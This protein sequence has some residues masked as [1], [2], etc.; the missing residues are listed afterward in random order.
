MNIE[1]RLGQSDSSGSYLIDKL[2]ARLHHVEKEDRLIASIMQMAQNL[3]CATAASLL[4]LDEGSHKLYF[5]YASG[6]V[7]NKLTQLHISK[8][9]GIAGWIVQHGKPLI[10]NNPE[11]NKSFYRQIDTATGFRTRSIIGVPIEIDRAVV[12]VIE[13]LNKRNDAD[14]TRDDL[15][16]LLD[17]ARTTARTVELTRMNLD[18]VTSFKGTVC[19]VMSLADAREISGSGHSKQVSEYAVGA[20]RE[21]GLAAED[22]LNIEYASIFHDIGK[23]ALPDR[24]LNKVEDLTDEEWIRMRRHPVTGYILLRDIPFLREAARLVLYHHERYDGLGYPEGLRGEAIPLGAR[25][26]AV[27]DAYAY[28]TTGHAYQEALTHGQAIAELSI[29]EDSQFCPVAV[30]ALK[31]YLD[32]VLP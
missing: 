11:K 16:A 4:L 8:Q 21:L 18:L 27:A 15:K 24:L 14:F 22:L 17:V 25:L 5:R 19:A 12:G 10:V 3:T 6:P 30:K 1:N 26:I 13:V 28:M 31:G 7:Q 29:Y 32:R 20:A 23:L 9:S 2:W